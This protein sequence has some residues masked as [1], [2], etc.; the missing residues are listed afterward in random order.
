MIKIEVIPA[1]TD[2]Y[3]FVIYDDKDKWAAVIDAGEAEPVI[4]FLELNDLNL[5]H[6]L[7]TH[8]HH[9]HIGGN[10]ELLAKYNCKIIGPAREITR[11]AN[12]DILVKEGNVINVNGLELE[13]FET[14]G[15]TMGHIIFYCQELSAAFTGD[16]IFSIGCGRL[17]EGS[18]DDM[19]GSLS[20][21]KNFPDDTTIYAAH[22]YTKSNIK[23][24]M[25]LDGDNEY[26][27]KYKLQVDRWRVDGKPTIPFS[28]KLEKKANPFLL[29]QNSNEL[30]I[31]RDKKDSF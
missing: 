9:D 25:T 16:V 4:D 10:L 28:L 24:A 2:N 22:E 5:T 15:H 27:N 29:A 19:F 23:F 12:M 14:P 3:I 30:K 26:L 11:I 8:H 1:L 17:F 18:A 20:K 7:N 6:I 21:I 13:I 31:I